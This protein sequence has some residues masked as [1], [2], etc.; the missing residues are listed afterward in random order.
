MVWAGNSIIVT[1]NQHAGVR[2]GYFDIRDG[3]H[4][5]PIPRPHRIQALAERLQQ[6]RVVR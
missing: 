1:A 6:L 5:G 3:V 2:Q 4:G